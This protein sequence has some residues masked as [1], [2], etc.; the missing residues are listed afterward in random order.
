M[1][2]CRSIVDLPS[3]TLIM[4]RMPRP[5]RPSAARWTRVALAGLVLAGCRDV[6]QPQT[7]AG[8]SDVGGTMVIAQ[9]SEPGTL[10][11]ALL[12]RIIEKQ[13]TDLLF[14]RLAEIGDDMNTVG[15]KGF[16]KQLAERWEWA[17]DSLSIAFHLDPRA[18]W[19]DG[20]PVRA[21]D[22]RYSVA[23]MKD[24]ALGSPSLPLI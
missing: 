6:Q 5:L 7:A 21:S 1:H 22:V 14:D 10:L 16:R 3:L 17:P 9:P 4:H 24:P 12:E 18:R 8:P 15:D 2:W 13:I 19:H 23:L 20:V 11:P